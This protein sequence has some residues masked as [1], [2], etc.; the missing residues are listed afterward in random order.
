VNA[1]ATHTHCWHHGGLAGFVACCS[2]TCKALKQSDAPV[3][4]K[5]HGGAYVSGTKRLAFWAGVRELQKHAE[6]RKAGSTGALIVDPDDLLRL[7]GELPCDQRDAM[8]LRYLA[9]LEAR[10][11]VLP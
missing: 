1:S 5:S 8:A 9:G 2:S 10:K 6:Q 11:V 4:E 3:E 7:I